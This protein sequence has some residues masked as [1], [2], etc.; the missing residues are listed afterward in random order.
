MSSNKSIHVYYPQIE[1][2]GPVG[3]KG[4]KGSNGPLGPPGPMGPMGLKGPYGPKGDFGDRGIKGSKGEKGERGPIGMCGHFGEKGNKGI[5]GQKGYS[6]DRIIDHYIN[7]NNGLILKFENDTISDPIYS[8]TGEKGDEGPKGDKGAIGLTGRNGFCG[9]KGEKGEKGSIGIKGN[10]GSLIKEINLVDSNIE[11]DLDDNRKIKLNMATKGTKGLKGEQGNRGNNAIGF[12]SRNL[13]YNL[14]FCAPFFMKAFTNY[15]VSNRF[16]VSK[17]KNLEFKKNNNG[18]I[19]YEIPNNSQTLK[20]IYFENYDEPITHLYNINNSNGNPL[21]GSFL[22]VDPIREPANTNLIMFSRGHNIIAK[23]IKVNAVSIPKKFSV[24]M[25]TVLKN[26]NEGLFYKNPFINDTQYILENVGKLTD[27]NNYDKYFYGN[28]LV[29]NYYYYTP[30]QIFFRFEIH[31]KQFEKEYN[32]YYT[33]DNGELLIGNS[34]TD[35]NFTSAFTL[36]SYTK[37]ISVNNNEEY[38][39]PD[40]SGWIVN[41]NNPTFKN[42][43]INVS[44][45]LN[46]GDTL[47]IRM[48]FSNPINEKSNISFNGN[49]VSIDNSTVLNEYNNIKTSIDDINM[50]ISIPQSYVAN[51][52]NDPNIYKLYAPSLLFTTV[53]VNEINFNVTLEKNI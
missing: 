37:W 26:T 13:N 9:Q 14:G 11:I 17:Y 40:F 19:E 41:T 30:I 5:K 2:E 32:F 31:S 49:I 34:K 4:S 25:S 39:I 24:N 18:I 15:E 47:C 16:Y 23:G 50:D 27:N 45:K 28:T 22:S 29:N 3:M 8:L 33:N 36:K 48:S 42:T 38:N 44:N 7:K 10:N 20:T 52:K 1:K 43:P 21:S 6:G 51:I 46:P 12:L 35:M 53:D